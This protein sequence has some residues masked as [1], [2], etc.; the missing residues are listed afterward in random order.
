[1]RDYAEGDELTM[2]YGL[3]PSCDLLVYLAS[4]PLPSPHDQVGLSGGRRRQP[5][6]CNDPLPRIKLLLLRKQGLLGP[7]ETIFKLELRSQ[8]E[9]AKTSEHE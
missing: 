7:E 1:M 3:R 4:F 5:P 8:N 6:Y 2:Y 9:S